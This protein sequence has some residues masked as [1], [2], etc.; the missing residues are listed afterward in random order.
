MTREE[1][2]HRNNR[3]RYAMQK[4]GRLDHDDPRKIDRVL[5]WHGFDRTEVELIEYWPDWT[6]IMLVDASRIVIDATG[7]THE[8]VM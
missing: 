2:L 6:S 5:Q 3:A 4:F 1:R 8:P 7:S